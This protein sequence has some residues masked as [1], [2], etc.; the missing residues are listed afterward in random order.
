MPCKFENACRHLRSMLRGGN[1]AFLPAARLSLGIHRGSRG[2]C[3]RYPSSRKEKIILGACD[4]KIVLVRPPSF[5][6]PIL[7]KFFGVNKRR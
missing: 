1:I 2:Y 7:K 3:R 4:M 6:T 5:L